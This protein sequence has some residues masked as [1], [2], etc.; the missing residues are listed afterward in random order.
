MR[1]FIRR[2]DHLSDTLARWFRSRLRAESRHARSAASAFASSAA[3]ARARSNT[4]RSNATSA[5][6]FIV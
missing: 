6:T 1:S 2:I 4:F 3:A 5:A